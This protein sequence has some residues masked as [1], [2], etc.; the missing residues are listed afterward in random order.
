MKILLKASFI[1]LS[2]FISCKMDGSLTGDNHVLN[3]ITLSGNISDMITGLSL[4]SSQVDI[5]S[6]YDFISLQADSIGNYATSVFQNTNY[7]SFNFIAKSDTNISICMLPIDYYPTCVGF[8][9]KYIFKHETGVEIYANIVITI[10]VTDEAEDIIQ[11]EIIL[12]GYIKNGYSFDTTYVDTTIYASKNIKLTDSLYT[13]LHFIPDEYHTR[14]FRLNFSIINKFLHTGV[15]SENTNPPSL[16]P[17][18]Y[19]TEYNSEYQLSE[20]HKVIK[21]YNSYSGDYGGGSNR[22]ILA[23]QIG[24]LELSSHSWGQQDPGT[25]FSIKLVEINKPIKKRCNLIWLIN[26]KSPNNTM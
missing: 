17:C 5:I 10:E 7:T 18:E 2:L 12:N 25:S 24:F 16:I 21:T 19:T 8:Y 15:Y 22:T 13:F 4:P 9:W 14:Y 6:E 3:K 26:N 23:N 11:E 1:I 20:K